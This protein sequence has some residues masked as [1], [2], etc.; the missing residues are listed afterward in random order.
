MRQR[1]PAQSNSGKAF[2]PALLDEHRGG[3]DEVHEAPRVLVQIGVRPARGRRSRWSAR[4]SEQ[5]DEEQ[6][7]AKS[8]DVRDSL[9]SLQPWGCREQYY[10]RPRP[11]SPEAHV[12]PGLCF[13]PNCNPWT[14]VDPG[15]RAR[16]RRI[17]IS[18]RR[19]AAPM[20]GAVVHRAGDPFTPWSFSHDRGIASQS[21]PPPITIVT[22][23]SYGSTLAAG[24]EPMLP[25]VHR[26]AGTHAGQTPEFS[27]SD[28]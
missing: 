17:P 9:H 1:D 27:T 2:H 5:R 8:P 20:C 23:P 4:D 22:G 10:G 15:V 7:G 21:S 6:T 24:R 16:T 18:T 13:A 12:R 3:L 25:A 26:K 11:Q 28:K 19:W 14:L